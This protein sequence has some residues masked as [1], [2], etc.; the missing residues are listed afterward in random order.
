M[1]FFYK[2]APIE[3]FTLFSLDA[4]CIIKA[5]VQHLDNQ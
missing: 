5:K 2:V 3:Q 4:L 1:L